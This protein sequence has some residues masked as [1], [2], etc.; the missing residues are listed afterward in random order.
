MLFVRPEKSGV[1]GGGKTAGVAAR[2]FGVWGLLE[3]K[4]K[5]HVYWLVEGDRK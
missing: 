4:M 2:D 1:P 3:G 5:V